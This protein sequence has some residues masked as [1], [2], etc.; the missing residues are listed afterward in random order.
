MTTV[1]WMEAST[2]GS[3][4][5]LPVKRCW[6]QRTRRAVVGDGAAAV[7]VHG[8][9]DGVA[10]RVALIPACTKQTHP[11]ARTARYCSAIAVRKNIMTSL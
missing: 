6:L 2:A 9:V 7:K 10:V 1:V 4:T 8:Y 3:C 11:P 5:T